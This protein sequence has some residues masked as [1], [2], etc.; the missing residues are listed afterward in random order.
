MILGCFVLL[1][2]LAAVGIFLMV[3]KN[4]REE[5][6]QEFLTEGIALVESGKYEEAV[7][8]LNEALQWSGDKMGE[9]EQEVLL[10]RAGAEY[11]LRDFDAALK[12]YETLQAAD[13][14]NVEYQRGVALCTLEKGDVNGALAMGVIDG[15]VYNRMAVDQIRA[16]DF[17]RALDSIDRGK[18]A[19][20]PSVMKDLTYNEAVVWE[21][22]GDYAKA[23]ELF[24][25]YVSQYG[26]DENAQREIDFLK[27]RVNGAENAGEGGESAGEGSAEG[28]SAGG[29]G[30]SETPAEGDGNT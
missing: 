20:D 12:T 15:Y 27:S 6:K 14:E 4:R 18:A 19:G 5:Q 25:S 28:E 29:E 26:S 13:S 8:K 11:R 17:D 23:L 1:L 30:E 3:R 2:L 24:E 22:K 7:A 9:F 21:N 10:Y 16:R